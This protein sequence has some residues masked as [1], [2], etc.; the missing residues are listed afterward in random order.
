M[1][2]SS[3]QRIAAIVVAI[4]ST[5]L[6]QI[7]GI[8]FWTEHTGPLVGWVWSISLDGAALWLWYRGGWVRLLAF[9][10]SLLMIIGPL[11]VLS[12][13]VVDRVMSV[14]VNTKIIESLKD[15]IS[16]T[17]F[18]YDKYI[19]SKVY[20]WA[21]DRTDGS[22]T[23]LDSL[24]EKQRDLLGKAELDPRDI[25][26]PIL[27]A[28]ALLVILVT[29][30]LAV[31]SLRSHYSPALRSTPK[32]KRKKG[33]SVAQVVMQIPESL[34]LSES[35]DTGHSGIERDATELTGIAETLRN[36]MELNRINQRE[37]A[38]NLGVRAAD[39]SMLL[40]HT[41]R[42]NQGKETISRKALSKIESGLQ[43]PGYDS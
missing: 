17:Q 25:A 28:S 19:D 38:N 1:T 24:R 2:M 10:G 21:R 18:H 33:K 40:N 37:V 29:Q 34:S 41:E 7:H 4:V 39:I 31:S 27:Q 12:A 5:A 3:G 13:P 32:P 42:C 6:L 26:L 14:S 30:V 20:N 23:R 22:K 8:R 11:Y 9:V 36:F 15:D 43:G 16:D 35:S